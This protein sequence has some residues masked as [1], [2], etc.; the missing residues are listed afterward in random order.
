[1]LVTEPETP[2]IPGKRSDGLSGKHLGPAEAQAAREA[3]MLL[4]GKWVPAILVCLRAR[5]LRP[6]EL[7]RR[8]PEPVSDKVLTATLRRL[9]AGGYVRRTAPDV[10]LGVTYDM[11]ASGRSL[12]VLV[13]FLAR[14][15]MADPPL[16]ELSPS[17]G[18][19]TEVTVSIKP[20]PSPEK[21][22]GR[23]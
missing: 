22:I 13:E 2:P 4:A 17:S 8:L 12:L 5:P 19:P 15:R 20:G 14:W 18:S 3:A 6:T 23:G 16:T 10:A 9:E 7:R 21:V 1:M 11:T